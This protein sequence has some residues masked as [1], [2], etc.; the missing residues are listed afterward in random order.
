MHEAGVTPGLM[1][2]NSLIAGCVRAEHPNEA[3]SVFH[4]MAQR[5]IKQ[6]QV[7]FSM[8]DCLLFASTSDAEGGDMLMRAGFT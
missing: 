8:I 7:P 3:L 4:L 5:G 1:T 2:Y 6:D